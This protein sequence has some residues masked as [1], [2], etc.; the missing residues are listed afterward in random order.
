MTSSRQRNSLLTGRVYQFCRIYPSWRQFWWFRYWLPIIISLEPFKTNI[1]VS[2]QTNEIIICLAM[3]WD[4]GISL[5]FFC[6]TRYENPLG[7]VSH[8]TH[9]LSIPGSESVLILEKLCTLPGAANDHNWSTFQG[10][11]LLQADTIYIYMR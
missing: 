5:K 4:I 11:Q 7:R 9:P 10:N 6:V 2:P 1:Q 3:G 8:P